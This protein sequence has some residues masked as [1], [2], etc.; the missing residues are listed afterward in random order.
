MRCQCGSEA[1]QKFGTYYRDG[2]R[3]QRLKCKLCDAVTSDTALRPLGNLRVPIEQAVQVVSLLVE[4]MTIRG[5]SR[6]TRLHQQTILNILEVAGEKS[7]ALLRDRIHGIAAENVE[8]DELYSYVGMRPEN[9]HPQDIGRGEIYCYLGTDR[10]SKLIISHLVGKRGAPGCVVLMKDLQ[11]RL[12]G[13][14]QLSTDGYPAY[15]APNGAVSKAF[16]GTVDYGIEVKQ[17]GRE[18]GPVG[19]YR[20][21]K[22][23]GAKRASV[24]GAPDMRTINTSRVERLNLSVRHFTRRFTRSTLGYSKTLRNHRHA[25]ALFIAHFNFCRCH[26]SLKNGIPRTPAMMAGLTEHPWTIGELLKA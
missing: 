18:E 11:S 4:G 7:A 15:C 23:L 17:F 5:A 3:I 10:D 25:V 21:A 26:S 12:S 24:I 16:G 20:P 14:T 19:R 1:F 2:N 9:A 22:C 8:V 13:R 6:I